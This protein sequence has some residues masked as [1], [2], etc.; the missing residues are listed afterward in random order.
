VSRRAWA[1]ID[2]WALQSNFKLSKTLL[3]LSKTVAVIKADA[4]GH[5]FSQC[6]WALSETDSFGVAHISEAMQLRGAG[7]TR[8]ILLLEGV[9]D[10]EEMELAARKGFWIAVG[11]A[12]QLMY[13]GTCKLKKPL[14]IWLKVNTGMNRLGV[15]VEQARRMFKEL[16]AMPNVAN[17]VLMSHFACADDLESAVTEIQINH[18]KD[19]VTGLDAESSL[20]NS[21]GI[22]AWKEKLQFLKQQWIRPGIMLYG[23]S[24]LISDFYSHGAGIPEKNNVIDQKLQPVMTLHSKLIEIKT[25][26]TG[27]SV[28]YGATWTADKTTLIGVISIGYGDGYPRHAK[29]GTPVLING[30]RVPLVGRV[31]MDMITVDLSTQPDAKIGDL[32]TLWGRDLSVDEVATCADTISYELFCKVTPRV[33][34]DYLKSKT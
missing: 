30:K 4:Y 16:K 23:S 34:R 14:N 15:S 2:L 6:A 29:N 20:A 33:P 21:A 26:K 9:Q 11:N 31:S 5:G 25:L 10:D 22:V 8:P 18:F 32:A 28:G 13:V 3:P 12:K 24:P 1:E 27:E 17:V 19:L 7:I